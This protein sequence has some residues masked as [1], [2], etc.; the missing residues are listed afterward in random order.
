MGKH[1]YH[2]NHMDL[3]SCWLLKYLKIRASMNSE[4]EV[5]KTF[6][7]LLCFDRITINNKSNFQVTLSVDFQY[8]GM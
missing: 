7:A 5:F 8:R 3:G 2:E 4:L 6:P 1:G